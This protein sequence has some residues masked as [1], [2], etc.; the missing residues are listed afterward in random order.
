V[1]KSAARCVVGIA[2]GAGG[3]KNSVIHLKKCKQEKERFYA[4]KQE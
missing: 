3:G 4:I 1:E 2:L